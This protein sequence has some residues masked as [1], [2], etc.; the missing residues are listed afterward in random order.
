MGSIAVDVW[1]SNEH[2]EIAKQVPRKLRRYIKIALLDVPFWTIVTL[3]TA[4][5]FILY[6][7]L[8]ENY[9]SRISWYPMS[10]V[11]ISFVYCFTC[12]VY[13]FVKGSK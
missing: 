5:L 1:L 8:D 9:F 7:D 4:Y 3:T 6:G 10:V 13:N 2:I 11:G 12:K